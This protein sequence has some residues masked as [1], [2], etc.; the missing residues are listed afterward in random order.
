MI[1][2]LFLNNLVITNEN[3]TT[4]NE[5]KVKIAGTFQSGK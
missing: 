2:P 3:P 5:M 4:T 1:F